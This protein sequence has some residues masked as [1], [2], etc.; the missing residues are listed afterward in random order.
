[1]PDRPPGNRRPDAGSAH[2][3]TR[4]SLPASTVPGD[5]ATRWSFRSARPAAAS[6]VETPV[7]PGNGILAGCQHPDRYRWR[8]RMPETIF[9]CPHLRQEPFWQRV[10]RRNF[11][12][13]SSVNGLTARAADR[14]DR[15]RNR[16]K[17]TRLASSPK[18]LRVR[19]PPVSCLRITSHT[20][21][22]SWIT[23]KIRVPGR[24]RILRVI[25]ASRIYPIYRAPRHGRRARGTRR[26]ARAG[27]GRGAER[28]RGGVA[29]GE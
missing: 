26:G 9:R 18:S 3:R 17:R 12:P 1:M 10:T 21:Y 7:A 19:G 4:N 8:T 14:P 29:Y 5:V 11:S 15:G 13:L 16:W 24:T 22:R 6:R 27:R 28:G 25:Q 20:S 2:G 23:R